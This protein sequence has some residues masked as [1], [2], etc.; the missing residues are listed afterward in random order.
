M[1]RLALVAALLAAPAAFAT[2]YN[3]DSAHSSANFTV[4]HMMVSKVNGHFKSVK[5]TVDLDEAAPES[6]SVNAEIDASSID[7]GNAGR[8][9]HLKSPDF[10]DTAKFPTITFKS[11][12]VTSSGA[13]KYAVIGDLTM[14][15]VT[16][17]V[18][19]D[20]EGFDHAQAMETPKGTVTKR[21]GTGTTTINR[22]DF[23]LGWNKA[24]D[25]GGVAVSDEVKVTLDLEIDAKGAEKAAK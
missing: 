8:D 3:I 18:T 20:V 6:S 17:E 1:I 14:H 11:K 21:G 23:G 25:K 22:K 5:G 16:K 19:L 9:G 10:F 13:G 15:G 2:P 7:T 12:K 24:L 4:K